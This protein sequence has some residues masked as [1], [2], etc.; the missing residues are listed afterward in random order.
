MPSEFKE[1]VSKLFL[2]IESDVGTTKLNG[3][4]LDALGIAVR[5]FR[6]KNEEDFLKQ[7][8]ELLELVKNTEPRIALVIDSLYGVWMALQEAKSKNHPDRHLFWEQQVLEALNEYQRET[9]EENKKIIDIGNL[10]IHKNDVILIHSISKTVL[11]VLFEAKRNGKK[12]RVII[13]EQESEKT[14]QLIETI[15]HH[16]IHFQVIP[17]YMLS[18]IE[19]EVTKVF[20]GG[21]TINNEL[22][23][24]GD[25]G[26]NAIV[27]EFHLKKIP[28]YLFLASRKF[29]LWKS[30]ESHHAYKVKNVRTFAGNRP[31]SFERIKFS[32]DRI[33]LEYYT[34]VI[35]E[36]GKMTIQEIKK[37]YEEKYKERASWRKEF[38]RE[39][40]ESL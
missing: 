22:N 10:E 14:H 13:A 27:S 17:E 40:N 24:V 30:R 16:Q 15:S 31:I 11:E 34:Y 21:V 39:R 4:V 38:L 1:R 2:E 37:L 3:M 8:F 23:V 32:H 35:T 26:S 7:F 12:F 29:S 6:E 28:I 18:H 36:L 20:L 5:D 33:P 9:K 19:S 25:A